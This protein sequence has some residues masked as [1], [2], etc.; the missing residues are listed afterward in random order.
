MEPHRHHPDT[1]EVILEEDTE[2][3]PEE[4]AAH[5]AEVAARADAEAQ[6]EI[7][8][9]QAEGAVELAKV[10]R[11]AL[12]E[13]ERVELEALREENRTLRQLAAPPEPEPLVVQAPEP[14]EPTEEIAD[15]EPPDVEGSPEPEHRSSKVGLG[16]W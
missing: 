4:A 14:A 13:E 8:R 6:V 7:A 2:P 10:E 3:T 9:I 16:M 12:G 15:A 5:A 1:G 11:S